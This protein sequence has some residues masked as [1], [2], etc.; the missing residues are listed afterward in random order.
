MALLVRCS[1]SAGRE[2]RAARAGAM[3]ALR[4]IEGIFSKV[5]KPLKELR[6]PAVFRR[7]CCNVVAAYCGR[8]ISWAAVRMSYRRRLRRGFGARGFGLHRRGRR[9]QGFYYLRD[10]FVGR[11]LG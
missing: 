10:W 8:V 11:C 1:K 3:K 2:A 9:L 5:M 6:G 4:S 7:Y